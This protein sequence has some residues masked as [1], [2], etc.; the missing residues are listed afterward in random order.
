MKRSKAKEGKTKNIIK[1]M[2]MKEDENGVEISMENGLI[3][4]IL[5]YG[6]DDLTDVIK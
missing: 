3:G 4:L 6:L 5:K 2:E 1:K